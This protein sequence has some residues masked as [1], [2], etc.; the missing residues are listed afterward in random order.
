MYFII[1]AFIKVLNSFKIKFTCDLCAILDGESVYE[2]IIRDL[3]T[4]LDIK[5]VQL[6]YPVPR[7]IKHIDKDSGKETPEVIA[8]QI[9]IFKS[10]ED[11]GKAYIATK[12]EAN[13]YA[14]KLSIIE[15]AIREYYSTHSAFDLIPESKF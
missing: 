4:E 11:D 5:L 15:G 14:K 8:D 9:R 1:K 3:P 6:T 7:I 12:L 10:Y 13:N 2:L